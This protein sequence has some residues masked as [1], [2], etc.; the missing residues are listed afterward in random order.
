MKPAAM[1]LPG[2]YLVSPGEG[3]AEGALNLNDWDGEQPE[4]LALFAQRLLVVA[5]DE[6][7]MP[8]S[9]F[10]IDWTPVSTST[11]I[12]GQAWRERQGTSVHFLRFRLIDPAGETLG[13]GGATAHIAEQ[14][15]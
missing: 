8:L 3:L 5:A 15:S 11:V 6:P 14:V 12:Y 13:A 4:A 7:E 2:F 9:A 10:S 1:D